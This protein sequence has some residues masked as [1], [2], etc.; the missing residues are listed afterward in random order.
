MSRCQRKQLLAHIAKMLSLPDPNEITHI[1][2]CVGSYYLVFRAKAA[3]NRDRWK[4]YKGKVTA[5]EMGVNF[6]QMQLTGI[7]GRDL[8]QVR[9]QI[10]R[11]TMG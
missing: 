2:H 1:I 6:T 9:Q 11:M 3:P 4:K 5:N 10:E 8:E 7:E